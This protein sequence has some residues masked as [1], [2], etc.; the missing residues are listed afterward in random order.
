MAVDRFIMIR[1][2]RL[3][4]KKCFNCD[5]KGHKHTHSRKPKNKKGA[6]MKNTINSTK[7]ENTEIKIKI[8]IN[9]AQVQM[10]NMFQLDTSS[11]VTLIN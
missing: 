9:F 5:Q 11:D 10:N 4:G 8:K 3:E 7:M 1:N 6:K 2:V